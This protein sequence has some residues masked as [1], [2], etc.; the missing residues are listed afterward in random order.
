MKETMIITGVSQGIGEVLARAFSKTYRVVGLDVKEDPKLDGVTY[1]QLDLGDHEAV[2]ETFDLIGE[3]FG[4]AHVLINNGGVSSLE[5]PMTELDV[6]TFKH[7]IDVNL[8]GTFACAKA[9]LALNENAEYGR[10][11]NVASTR[12]LQN[13]PDWEAYGASKGGIVA[14]TH[15][16]AVSLA[17]RPITVNAVSPGWIH[18][19]EEAL[20]DIDHR[21]HPSGRVGKPTDIVRA[22]TYLIDR[23]NDFVNGHNLIVDGGMT[24]KMIYEP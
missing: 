1:M 6:E 10:I 13:E 21:Q 5:K 17:E 18:T 3:Q 14:L 7:V 19:S 8:V 15:S 22:V 12:A 20:R 23:D 2:A 11:V 24:K 9:F 4:T 16:M